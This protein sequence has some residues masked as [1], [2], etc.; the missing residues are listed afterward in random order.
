MTV[1]QL[2]EAEKIDKDFMS[3]NFDSDY[4]LKCG[5]FV[6]E[7]WKVEIDFL[8]PKQGA[9]LTKILDDCVEKRIEG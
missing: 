7:H 1:Q 9:W 8:T 4:W 3:E 6:L 5:N 2:F